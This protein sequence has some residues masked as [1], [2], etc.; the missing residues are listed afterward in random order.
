[1]QLDR[2]AEARH[3]HMLLVAQDIRAVVR[4]LVGDQLAVGSQRRC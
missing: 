3:I 1:M 4:T 2:E